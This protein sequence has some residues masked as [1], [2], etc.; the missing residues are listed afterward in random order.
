VSSYGSKGATHTTT[1]DSSLFLVLF[2][3][4]LVSLACAWFRKRLVLGIA[5]ALYG[6]SVFNLHYWGSASRSSSSAR[7]T[8][9]GPTA[10][11]RSSRLP[12]R[13]ATLR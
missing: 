5:L 11:S 6:L 7:G 8:W 9:S 12:K 10:S 3:L 1:V 4:A 2:G 13:G